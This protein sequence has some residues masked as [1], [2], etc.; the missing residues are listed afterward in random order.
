MIGETIVA[1]LCVIALLIWMLIMAVVGLTRRLARVER[2]IALT[3]GHSAAGRT[4]DW[5]PEW[6]T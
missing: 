5:T 1:L 6:C 4:E 2:I 3:H